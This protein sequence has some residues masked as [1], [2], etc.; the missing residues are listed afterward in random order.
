MRFYTKM[1]LLNKLLLR[2]R[3]FDD[4]DDVI[5]VVC[6]PPFIKLSRWYIMASLNG[7]WHESSSQTIFSKCECKCDIMWSLFVNVTKREVNVWKLCIGWWK[8]EMKM[9]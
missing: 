3:H 2:R 4:H 1:F 9:Y 5:D 7:N 8:F 6:E